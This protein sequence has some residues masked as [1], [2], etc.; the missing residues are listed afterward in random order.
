MT[1]FI[2]LLRKSIFEL[3]R[4]PGFLLIAWLA[5]M[6]AL[7]FLYRLFGEQILLQGL[8]LA[9]LL[10]V[11]F[12][13]NVL[14]RAWGWWGMLRTAL[15]VGLLAW[16]VQA[17]VIRSGL[18]YGNL[19]YTPSL[20]PQLLGIP[21]L[22]PLLWLMMLPA[23]WA[24]AKLITHKLTGCLMRIAFILF[25]AI[26]FTAWGFYI[27]PLMA[28]LGLLQ[29]TPSGGLYGTPW[30]NY[31]GWLLVSGVITFG[32]SPKRIPGAALLLVYTLTWLVEFVT[33]LVFGGLTL[34]A[35]IGFLLM[36]MMILLAA[37]STR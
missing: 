6:L 11:A 28:H 19:H 29:W 32:A 22:I 25:S 31:T 8:A 2:Q 10:Q 20:Q 7:P 23:A 16:V 17:I 21:I 5:V 26:G 3:K 37:I 1:N 27:D 34:A 36:G 13:L 30:L 33:L 9:V 18:P 35:L 24:V 14:Y 12:V 15:E 4:Y